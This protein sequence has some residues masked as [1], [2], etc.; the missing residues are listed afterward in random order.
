MGR[1]EARPRIPFA[2]TKKFFAV[3]ASYSTYGTIMDRQKDF[4]L[5]LSTT[6]RDVVCKW[7]FECEIPKVRP[8]YALGLLKDFLAT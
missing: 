6:A 2:D 4:V 3:D 7:D 8:R 5:G 1:S